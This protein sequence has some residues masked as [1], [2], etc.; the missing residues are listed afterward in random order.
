MCMS[1]IRPYCC[2]VLDPCVSP[3][4]HGFREMGAQVAIS[5]FEDAAL[6]AAVR[7]SLT[8]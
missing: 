8:C 6:I 1:S 2:G 4:A 5:D 7:R 3:S